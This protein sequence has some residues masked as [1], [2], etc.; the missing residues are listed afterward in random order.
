MRL[1]LE[2]LTF[3]LVIYVASQN[4]WYAL[5]GFVAYFVLLFIPYIQIIVA[6]VAAFFSAG[7]VGYL[8]LGEMGLGAPSYV[9]WFFGIFTFV[10][11][12]ANHAQ[13]FTGLP[14][15]GRVARAIEE[16]KA[17]KREQKMSKPRAMYFNGERIR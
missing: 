9:C 13:F 8:I 10:L 1:F 7:V 17:R 4:F 15:L 6:L 16:R 5:I 2:A 14:G 3:A 11:T 12:I